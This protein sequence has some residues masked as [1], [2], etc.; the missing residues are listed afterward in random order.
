MTK[1][2]GDDRPTGIGITQCLV[3]FLMMKNSC[4]ICLLVLAA[5]A[6]TV[7]PGLNLAPNPS[8]EQDSKRLGGWLP[9]G[10]LKVN[11]PERLQIV[12]AHGYRS[13]RSLRVTTGPFNTPESF[14]A[15]LF[16]AD[17]NGGEGERTVES[18][19]GIT[20]VRT[21][22]LRLNPEVQEVHAR[23]RISGDPAAAFRLSLV[24]TGRSGRKPVV[25]IHRD[26]QK[27]F[28]DP[29]GGKWRLMEL[30]ARKPEGA[31]QVQL[32]V[33]TNGEE[34][35]HLDDVGVEFLRRPTVRLWVNQLGHEA[36]SLAKRV[37]LESSTELKHASPA[38]LTNLKNSETVKTLD[39]KQHGYIK[40]LNA[41]YWSADFSDVQSEGKYAVV[42]EANKN[43]LISAPFNIADNLV[44]PET[45]EASIRFYYE[46]R[47]GMLIPGVHAA[48]H[49]DDATLPD[50]TWRDLS[51]GWHDAGDY[52]KYN[53]LTPD[54]L[55]ALSLLAVGYLDADGNL[56][57]NEQIPVK[58]VKEIIWGMQWIDKMLDPVSLKLLDQVYSGYRYWGEPEKETD[59]LPDTD[60]ERPVKSSNGD[61]SHLAVIYARTALILKHSS[62]QQLRQKGLHYAKLAER[63]FAETGGNLTT[64]LAV[65]QATGNRKYIDTA[66]NRVAEW[67]DQGA[68]GTHFATLAKFAILTGDET[69]SDELKP[70]ARKRVKELNQLCLNPFGAAMRR[71]KDG[72][73]TYCRE[74]EDVNDWYVG[75]SAYRLDI[76]IE[77]LLA[78]GVGVTEGRTL[79]EFQVN[80][81]LGCN[82]MGVS[83]MEGV[84]TRFVPGYHHRYNAIPGNPRGAVTGAILNGFIRAFPHIDKPWLDLSEEPNADYHSNEPWLLQNNRWTELLALWKR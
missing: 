48:C 39:W 41:Y 78:S 52:N 4:L 15:K 68:L 7:H 33:E 79:A 1:A 67:R 6:V 11:E 55:R 24:W 44:V 47:C 60:D 37:V 20:G 65:S 13:S 16:F 84:G 8:F 34:T 70:H 27:K 9:L 83:M 69:L 31:L 57:P 35:F 22:A 2:I 80:W 19:N 32:C 26:V 51:G 74:I 42:M 53:G 46:Q 5:M 63:L 81:I 59:N 3:C 58:L 14:S 28:T 38:H 82:P 64:L 75:E 36:R 18:S 71:A 30:R 76:A 10:Q 72:S 61:R 43:R 40:N 49:L 50:G 77:G 45:L 54:A 66:R 23:T 21:I 25:E 29:S 17:Y 62:N 73:L 12:E 56:A